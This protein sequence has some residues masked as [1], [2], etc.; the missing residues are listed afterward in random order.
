MQ[1]IID[2]TLAIAQRLS[3]AE[4]PYMVSGSVAASFHSV[5]RMTNDID[6]VINI[7]NKERNKILNLFKD[8]YYI[9]QQAIDDAFAGIGMFNIIHNKS[10]VKCDLILL[11][12]DEFSRSAFLRACKV[13][14]DGFELRVISLEDLILQ[15]LLWKK[16]TGSERQLQDVSNVI[17]ANKLNIDKKYLYEWAKKIKVMHDVEKYFA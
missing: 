17:E 10:I 1:E 13:K 7:S 12:S 8:E 6:I 14:V 4:I 11:K 15:K 5:T 2:I 16:E 3:N 9:S